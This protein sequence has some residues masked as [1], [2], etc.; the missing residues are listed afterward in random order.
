MQPAVPWVDLPVPRQLVVPALE[1]VPVLVQE[2]QVVLL[3]AGARTRP[4][5]GPTQL[6]AL[7]ALVALAALADKV[8]THP[9]ERVELVVAPVEVQPEAVQRPVLAWPGLAWPGLAWRVIHQAPQRLD[10]RRFLLGFSDP[11]RRSRSMSVGYRVLMNMSF[12]RGP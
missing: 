12:S 3:L 7:A 6:A 1:V 2:L 9:V 11:P 8:A 4:R 5:Q 10:R